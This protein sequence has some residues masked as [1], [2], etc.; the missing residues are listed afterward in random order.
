MK[1][2]TDAIRVRVHT[3]AHQHRIAAG[4]SGAFLCGCVVRVGQT[5]FCSLRALLLAG[6]LVYLPACSFRAALAFLH[7]FDI[8][9][10]G[11]IYEFYTYSTVSVHPNLFLSLPP[12]IL[13]ETLSGAPTRGISPDLGNILLGKWPFSELYKIFY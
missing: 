1:M 3:L 8:L 2:S 4:H 13:A 5:E 9:F 7:Q 6:V 10:H 12:F 11:S